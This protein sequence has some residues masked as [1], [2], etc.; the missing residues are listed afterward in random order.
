LSN[1]SI[2][3]VDGVPWKGA[4]LALVKLG[5]GMKNPATASRVCA[6]IEK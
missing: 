4:S 5:F 1:L 6:E 3:F 2:D